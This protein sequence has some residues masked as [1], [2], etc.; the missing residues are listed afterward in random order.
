MQLLFIVAHCCSFNNNVNNN[1]CVNENM[2]FANKSFIIIC[3]RCCCTVRRSMLIIQTNLLTDNNIC[4]YT[5]VYRRI[6]RDFMRL[7]FTITFSVNENVQ[8]IQFT[9]Y[10][11]FLSE[12]RASNPFRKF[13]ISG[14][15][16]T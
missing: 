10:I 4:L 12:L 16:I 9:V 11:M 2:F 1:S 15:S 5:V 3:L 8:R 14:K 6:K 7:Y 13:I